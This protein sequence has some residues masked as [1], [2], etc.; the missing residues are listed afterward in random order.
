[1]DSNLESVLGALR[2]N[3]LASLSNAAQGAQQVQA[4][5]AVGQ[6]ADQSVNARDLNT[7]SLPVDPN[8]GRNL[9]IVV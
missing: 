3:T 2:A 7:A 5:D 9:N 1:M 4:R 6:V 8:R